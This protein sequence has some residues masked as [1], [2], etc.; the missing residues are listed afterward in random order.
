MKT[1]TS[2]PVF[3]GS[4]KLYREQAAFHAYSTV[5]GPA[6]EFTRLWSS[7]ASAPKRRLNRRHGRPA[8][9]F[10]ETNGARLVRRLR[11]YIASG[12]PLT[13]PMEAAL[14]ALGAID[15]NCLSDCLDRPA[16]VGGVRLP[17]LKEGEAIRIA[18]AKDTGTTRAEDARLA[19]LRAEIAADLDWRDVVM[20]RACEIDGFRR[21]GITPIPQAASEERAASQSR[22]QEETRRSSRCA[23]W[24]RKVVRFLLRRIEP[25]S[26]DPETHV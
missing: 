12:R 16:F 11:S 4:E 15:S 21:R 24:L 3:S 18:H 23:A 19:M 6:D 25:H 26:P 20:Q 2:V 8:K 1:P 5:L 7:D 14:A 17:A 9:K 10:R 13:P 22:S